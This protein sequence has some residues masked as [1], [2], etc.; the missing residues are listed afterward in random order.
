MF[1]F[2]TTTAKVEKWDIFAEIFQISIATS[3]S[4]CTHIVHEHMYMGVSTS[5]EI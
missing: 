5:V 3:L 4:M 1:L 2:V